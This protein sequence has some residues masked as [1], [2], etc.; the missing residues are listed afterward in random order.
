MKE[1]E[2]QT[3]VGKPRSVLMVRTFAQITFLVLP[4]SSVL[5]YEIDQ[6]F[7]V[8]FCGVAFSV[9]PELA[10]NGVQTLNRNRKP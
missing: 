5:L 6:Y 8:F 1:S 2:K 4:L 3:H 10:L 9:L 7:E